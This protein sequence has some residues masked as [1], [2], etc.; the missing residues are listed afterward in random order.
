MTAL[1]LIVDVPGPCVAW[2][3][4]A[5]GKD[6][7]RR[8]PTRQRAY[9]AHVAA[10][11]W[12]ARA[13]HPAPPPMDGRMSVRVYVC[14]ADL[15]QRDVDNAAKTVLDACNRVLWSDD[16]QVD[17][18][19]SERLEPS[20]THARIVLLEGGDRVLGSYPEKLSADALRSLEG[21]GV[22]VRLE[23]GI[24]VAGQPGDD[25]VELGLRAALLLDLGDVEDV[26]AGEAH[27]VDAMRRHADLW[28]VIEACD[29]HR[30]GSSC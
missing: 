26:D 15:R 6:G 24:V 30:G 20:K 10:C 13:R 25:L 3:R 28:S 23:G 21:L 19:G 22:E 7:R 12:A 1:P 16:A 14:A 29:E 2:Q 18:L 17:Y 11:A 8:T 4:T 9:Q 5:T 27:S